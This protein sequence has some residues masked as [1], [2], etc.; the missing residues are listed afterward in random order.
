M[1]PRR[2]VPDRLPEASPPQLPPSRQIAVLPDYDVEDEATYRALD[3]LDLDL[4][5]REAQSVEFDGCHFKGTDLGETVLDKSGFADCLVENCN[6]ANLRASDASI[7]RVRISMSRM[8]GFQVIN[9]GLRDVSFVDCRLD[10]STFR[11]CTLTDVVFS[12]CNLTRVDFTNADLSRA[13]FVDCQLAGA[14]FSHANVSG[15]RFTRCEL[16]DIDG[17]T[18]MRGAVVEGHNLI[19]L[20][21]TLA[22]GLGITIE[23]PE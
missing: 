17:V 15:T 5:G 12:E 21:H 8:T 7:R 1:P 10:L 22:A 2:F 3:F 13:R 14:Q 4:T 18:S 19:A 20:A 23:T 16:V 9:G 6:L 11:F